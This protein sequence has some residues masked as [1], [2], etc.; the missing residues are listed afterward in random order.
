ML[1]LG[2]KNVYQALP[3]FFCV[4]VSV[5]NS[6]ILFF[7]WYRIKNKTTTGKPPKWSSS[8][9]TILLTA[10]KQ[11]SFMQ[12]AH[13]SGMP[14]QSIKKRNSGKKRYWFGLQW[15]M[16]DRCSLRQRPR[17][18]HNKLVQVCWISP[19]CLDCV[20]P[21]PVKHSNDT[22]HMRMQKRWL[23]AKECTWSTNEQQ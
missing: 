22:G 19:F 21:S 13:A 2:V 11:A 20:G 6:V 5:Q 18:T 15:Q 9:D 12:L 10:N 1:G 17:N 23:L 14:S 4:I 8:G 16:P 7:L 3:R